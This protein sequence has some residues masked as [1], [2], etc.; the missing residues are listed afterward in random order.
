MVWKN[1]LIK[2]SHVFFA[3]STTVSTPTQESKNRG[4]QSAGRFGRFDLEAAESVQNLDEVSERGG[5][6]LLEA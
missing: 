3:L 4:N 5:W 6:M 2:Q 1:A